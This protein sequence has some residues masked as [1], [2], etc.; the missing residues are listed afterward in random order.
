MEAGALAV[1]ERPR[2][3]GHADF[4][5]TAKELLRTVKL[6]SEVRVV[7]RRPDRAKAPV[8][9]PA[10][11]V[12]PAGATA[13]VHLVAIGASTGGPPALRTILSGLPDAFPVPVVIVQHIPSGFDR[14]LAQ[15]LA[16]SSHGPVHLARHDQSLLSG[17]TY[18]AP[19]GLQMAITKGDR[20]RLTKPETEN[21]ICPSVSHLLRSV[22]KSHGASAIGVLLSGMGKDGA[23]ALKTMKNYGA[24][25]IV[26]DRQSCVVYGMPGEAIELDAA[27]YILSPQEIASMLR[28]LVP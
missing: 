20:V 12:A 24:V 14:G 7:T 8:S 6:M 9:E 22:A 15:W 21:G 13:G 11:E 17:H 16:E 10:S 18:V 4:E 1:I 28:V 26:Q 2:G 19:S 5:A 3:V 25:T 27:K 23:E